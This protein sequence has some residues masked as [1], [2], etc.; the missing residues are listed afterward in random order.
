MRAISRVGRE[1]EFKDITGRLK[2]GITLKKTTMD[3]AEITLEFDP[4]GEICGKDAAGCHFTASHRIV[5]RADY[6]NLL[7]EVLTHEIGHFFGLSDQYYATHFNTSAPYSNNGLHNSIMRHNDY[8]TCDDADGFINLITL[9]LS[10]RGRPTRLAQRSWKSLCK[11]SRDTYQ[12]SQTLYREDS[13][14]ILETNLFP[15]FQVTDHERYITRDKE[16]QIGSIFSPY[17]IAGLCPKDSSQLSLRNFRHNPWQHAL[18]IWCNTGTQ[19]KEPNW[20]FPLQFGNDW[21]VYAPVPQERREMSQS[22]IVSFHNHE[23]E[24]VEL[25][26]QDN[27]SWPAQ[28]YILS[29]DLVHN[30]YTLTWVYAIPTGKDSYREETV[31]YS[32]PGKSLRNRLVTLS[33]FSPRQR[34]WFVKLEQELNVQLRHVQSF[35]KNFYRP[36]LE[37]PN[38]Q[39]AQK[40]VKQQLGRR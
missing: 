10:Q 2:R 24:R 36:L 39:N 4:T 16:Q 33:K 38:R 25:G 37:Q 30:A 23:L 34:Q 1:E 29:R 40:A 3:R 5:V 21:K 32:V 6:R 35:Y 11:D 18:E 19:E 28:R 9:R 15:L 26:Q 20:V 31:S 17:A 7:Q 27:S 14:T 12:N 13:E 22:I 8:L